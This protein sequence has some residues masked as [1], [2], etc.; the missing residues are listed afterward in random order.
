MYNIKMT[1]DTN[2]NNKHKILI[3]EDDS[4]LRNVLGRTF[5]G[6]GFEVIEAED[7]ALGLELA[8]KEQPAIIL[9]DILM[10]KLLGT[11]VVKEISSRSPDLLKRIIIITSAVESEYLASVLEY[12]V[13]TY[14]LK[15]D[16]ELV[17]IVKKVHERMSALNIK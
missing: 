16:H 14:V 4:L 17:D 10:P 12:G 3:I 15:G 9:L 13:T 5:A 6:E 2:K 8:I 1:Q 11:G 7:G